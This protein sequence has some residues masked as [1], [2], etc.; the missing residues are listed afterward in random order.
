MGTQVGA[1]GMQ[2]ETRDSGRHR[3]DAG[4]HHGDTVD[5]GEAGR[6]H[7]DAGRQDLEAESRPAGPGRNW[8]T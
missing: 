4:R 3:G 1:A 5:T 8:H 7:R 2:V 6:H